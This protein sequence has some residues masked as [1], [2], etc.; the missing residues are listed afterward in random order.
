V[1]INKNFINILS[2]C[3]EKFNISGNSQNKIAQACA[4]HDHR[5]I[6]EEIIDEIDLNFIATVAA[7]FG[8]IDLVKYLLSKNFKFNYDEI[9][10]NAVEKCD[11]NF[12]V[13][14]LMKYGAENFTDIGLE[15]AKYNRLDIID[16]ISSHCSNYDFNSCS[17]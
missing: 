1:G 6:L 14:Y 16:E 17:V 3:K 7:K 4:I 12:F 11:L 10:I 15:A 8:H 2:L 5:S 13:R 9:V